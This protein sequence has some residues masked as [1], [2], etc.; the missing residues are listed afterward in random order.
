MVA[1]TIPL[2]GL[3]GLAFLD[4]TYDR[5]VAAFQTD[6]ELRRDLEAFADRAPAIASAEALVRDTR[7]LRVVLGAFGLEDELPKRAF[8]RKVI[9]EGTLDPTS[10]ANRLADPAW[11]KLADATAFGNFGNGLA[12]ASTRN[13][14]AEAYRVRQFERAVG[15]V[16]TDL[17]LALNFRRGIGEIAASATVDSSG[18]FRIMGS[19]PLRTVVEAAFG[20]P[21]SFGR[22]DIDQQRG[23]LEAISRRR[24]GSPSA[25]VFADSANVEA[26]VR[27]FLLRAQIAAGPAP[28]APGVTALAILR[29]GS[30][31]GGVTAGLVASSL[32]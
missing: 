28:G 8:I 14:I 2:G 6:A 27:D 24:F 19:R 12:L 3:A 16:D 21:E 7:V 31:G 18:W 4:R 32:L 1:P 30:P 13:E 26:V 9:E 5:Q 17:R 20:L 25:S 23:E 10:L 15:N 29:A 11:K 22:L